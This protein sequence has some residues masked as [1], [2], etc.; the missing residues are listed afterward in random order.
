MP[1]RAGRHIIFAVWYVALAAGSRARL[2]C[3][4]CLSVRRRRKQGVQMIEAGTRPHVA[5]PQLDGET[6]AAVLLRGPLDVETAVRYASEIGHALD[7]A[8]SRGIVHRALRPENVMITA[9]G[10]RLLDGEAAAA[11]PYMAPEQL[12]GQPSDTP[13]D[14]FAFGAMFYE[15]LTGHRPFIA[16]A[17]ASALPQTLGLM[18]PPPSS[19]NRAVSPA[20]DAVVARCL[21]RTP[22]DRWPTVR[23]VL[24]S[25]T[26][27]VHAS[28]DMYAAP[29]WSYAAA[30]A[31]TV[32]IVVAAGCPYLN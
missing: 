1:T 32:L 4:G 2:D 27:A 12:A 19:L 29:R 10:A 14:V 11:G 9:D 22:A 17:G 5:D 7:S 25:L 18:P 24:N 15:M 21:A 3:V 16:T 6:L 26:L 20:I 13:A 31:A 8:H 30:A 23:A 28:P